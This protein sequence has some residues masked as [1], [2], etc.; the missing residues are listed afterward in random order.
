MAKK[1]EEQEEL[2][3][4]LF[5]AFKFLDEPI[6]SSV[7]EKKKSKEETPDEDL[8][9]LRLEAEAKA[10]EESEKA[11]NTKSNKK[12]VTEEPTEEVEE[13][14]I[15]EEVEEIKSSGIK[16]FAKYM[17][18]KGILDFNE[19]EFEDSEDGLEKVV[20]N[21]VKKGINEYKSSIPEDG[22]KFLEFI[23]NGGNPQDFH[24]LYYSDAS[25]EDFDI[26]EE[27]NGKYVI[28]QG[29]EAEGY[30]PED[31]EEE[32][33]N[34]E[35]LGNW[36]KKAQLHLK[37]L[38]KA[39]KLQKETLLEA[40]KSYAKKQ[41]EERV[42]QWDKFKKGL[43]DKEQIGGFK[44]TS[45]MKSDTWDYMA[46]PVDKKTGKSQ[47]Q[48]DQENNPDAQYMYAYLLKNKWDAKSL[49][50]QVES[51]QVSKLRSKLENYTNSGAKVRTT[52]KE[53]NRVESKEAGFSAFKE[54]LNQ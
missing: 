42:E 34:I 27:E 2:N 47:M 12:P 5:D 45:K 22:Q 4:G 35:R 6:P 51:K 3:E 54:Y 1:N 18:D 24:K 10:L 28:K 44:W 30:T 23:E 9:K 49:E 32:L 53:N 11:A 7:T 39:E 25:F 16:E 29:L 36:E 21:T 43:F 33:E 46:K 40:Q 15:E 50:R 41:E 20:V 31:I 14:I 13:E 8:E 38:Q 52:I 17:A 19:E 37:K 26:S 48:I